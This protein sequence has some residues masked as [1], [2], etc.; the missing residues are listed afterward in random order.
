MFAEME[1][2]GWLMF[3]L[4][5][6]TQFRVFVWSQV[7]REAEAAFWPRELAGRQVERKNTVKLERL[8]DLRW[9]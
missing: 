5:A 9:I 2:G 1:M 7:G 4:G 8:A 6:Y 3:A